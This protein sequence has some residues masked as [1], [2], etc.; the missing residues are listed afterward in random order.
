MEDLGGVLPRNNDNVARALRVYLSSIHEAAARH[1]NGCLH[2]VV[3][4]LAVA[5]SIPSSW[6]VVKTQQHGSRAMHAI[7]CCGCRHTFASTT[8]ESHCCI[9]TYKTPNNK[10]ALAEVR[11]RCR[12]NTTQSTLANFYVQSASGPYRCTK[13]TVTAFFYIFFSILLTRNV[14]RHDDHPVSI[15]LTTIMSEA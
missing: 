15:D 7:F 14:S 13:K 4:W 10:A 3:V 2:R 9:S 8:R 11:G 5:G 1:K 6:S 12:H